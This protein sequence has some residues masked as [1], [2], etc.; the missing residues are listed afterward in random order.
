MGQSPLLSAYA[1]WVAWSLPAIEI[2]IAIGLSIPRY[3]KWGL[4]GFYGMMIMF[5]TYIFIILNFADFVPCSCGGILEQ[6]GWK[7]H[8]LF[9]IGFVALSLVAILFSYDKS[10]GL[11]KAAWSLFSLAIFGAATVAL[12]YLGSEK[13]MKRNNAFV[14]R[15][16]PHP[17]EKIGEYNLGYN[18]YYI[19]GMDEQT[20]YLGNY[21][22]PLS[23]T[24]LD[25]SSGQFKEFRIEINKMDLPY[26]RVKILVKPPYFYVGDGTI[27]ILFKG[28]IADWKASV[29]SYGDAYFLDYII[30]DSTEI[31]FVTISSETKSKTI[32]LL[33]HTSDSNQIFLNTSILKKQLHGLFDTDGMLLWNSL[34]QQF[35]YPYY[36]RNTFEVFDNDLKAI[37]T[38]NTIDTISQAILDVAYYQDKNQYKKSGNSIMVNRYSTT[39]GHYLYINS[40]RLGKYEDAEV[41][42]SASIIDVYDIRNNTYAFSFYLYHQPGKKLREFRIY[43][44]ILVALVDDILWLYRLKRKFFGT[45]D[46][47][48][49][50]AQYQEEGR[51]PVEKSRP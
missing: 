44:N 1:H 24:T 4:Y 20:I 15:Y 33:T 37:Y 25:V 5:T 38:G 6:M 31:G 49:Y 32:G 47:Q 14:R 48:Q 10:F 51:T 34:H 7:E 9:N 50:T 17:I 2:L 45:K 8:L 46:T 28:N 41:L 29:F 11:K 39:S 26:S 42:N 18:S 23:M 3:R 43:K 22:T 13:Q 27:P 19:A 16:I 36:Y 40:D 21:T 30:S 12:L 35:I